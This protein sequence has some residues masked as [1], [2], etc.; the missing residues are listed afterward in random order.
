M[1]GKCLRVVAWLLTA[2]AWSQLPFGRP[3]PAP[4]KDVVITSRAEVLK[5]RLLGCVAEHCSLDGVAIDRRDIVWIGLSVVL[6]PPMATQTA[7]D[8]VHRYDRSV[9]VTKLLG[10]NSRQVV[11]ERG[12]YPRS[13]VKWI[14]LALYGASLPGPVGGSSVRPTPRPEG[15]PT[16]VP[17]GIPTPATPQPTPRSTPQPSPAPTAQPTVPPPTP[18]T[19]TPSQPSPGYGERGALWLGVV[20]MQHRG[21]TGE[22]YRFDLTA[23]VQV[24]LR[25]Y[26]HPLFCRVTGG[27]GWI[28]VGTM[29]K[30]EYEGT[31]LASS[32][33]YQKGSLTCRGS[34]ESTILRPEPGLSSTSAIFIKMTNIDTAGCLGFDIPLGATDGTYYLSFATKDQ[35]LYTCT[36]PNVATTLHQMAFECPSVGVHPGAPPANCGDQE[37]RRLEADGTI[38]RGF[39]VTRCIGLPRAVSWSVCREGVVCPAPPDPPPAGPGS[40][41][42]GTSPTPDPCGDLASHQAQVEVLWDQRQAYALALEEDWQRLQQAHQTLRDNLE[43]YRALLD[44]CA[45]WDIVGETLE[46]GA[47]NAGELVEFMTKVRGWR[48]LLQRPGGKEWDCHRWW[49]G[50]ATGRDRGI[51]A[52]DP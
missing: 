4:L 44:A 32:Y 43:G 16:P 28:R 13:D 17:P 27:A 35:L 45:I 3:T 25:E 30:L 40:V 23:T 21:T 7:V 11:T 24:R 39:Y 9:E 48:K 52:G 33:L 5:G 51:C 41:P 22:G 49:R 19:P 10:I 26:R 15:Q 34:G 31:R 20:R 50:V 1:G 46:A 6:P 47:G 8:E 36:E 18:A 37:V 42:P 38:M 14:H 2:P 29:V 12:S